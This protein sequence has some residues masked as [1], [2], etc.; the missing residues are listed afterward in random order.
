M[1]LLKNKSLLQSSV[2]AN[3]TMN[4]EREA[5]GDNSYQKDI[6]V[7]PYVFLKNHVK[8]KNK[9]RWLDI[10][11][12]RGKALIQVANKFEDEKLEADIEFIG[13]D[14]ISMFDTIPH[15]VRNVQLLE[16]TIEEFDTNLS[17]D[18][19]TCVHG[20]HYI[21]DKLGIIEKYTQY[22][23]NESLFVCNLDTNNILDENGVNI[24]RQVNK[25]FREQALDYNTRKKILTS[26]GRKNIK[27]PLR[28]LGADDQY[29]KNYTGQRSVS[30]YYQY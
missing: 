29:G 26:I 12:G 9:I 21:G 1:K 17:F 27:F 14:L 30:S 10:C 5:Y 16:S 25:L 13:I 11:C 7:N 22:L 19:I 23:E 2:V 15:H 24:S 28:Y 4:R 20:L 8:S 6:Y 3:C 18:L